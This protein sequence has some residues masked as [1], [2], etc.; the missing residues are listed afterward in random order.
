M[1]GSG[2]YGNKALFILNAERY[3]CATKEQKTNYCCQPPMFCKCMQQTC[4]GYNVEM[5]ISAALLR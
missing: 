5:L 4:K 2:Y 1:T 3:I